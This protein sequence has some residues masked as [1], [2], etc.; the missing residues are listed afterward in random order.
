MGKI[1]GNSVN[2]ELVA[3]IPIYRW[4]TQGF[5]WVLLALLGSHLVDL[6]PLVQRF[7]LAEAIWLPP[8]GAPPFPYTSEDVL[9]KEKNGFSNVT[10]SGIPILYRQNLF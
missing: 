1:K 10:I 6:D 5:F 2:L 9:R 4:R 3:Y 8:P 7:P